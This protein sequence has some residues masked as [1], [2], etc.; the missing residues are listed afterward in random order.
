MTFERGTMVY[1]ADGLYD[2]QRSPHNAYLQSKGYDGDNPWADYANAGVV[3][4]E[5]A[6][7][8]MFRNAYEP[9]NIRE[10]DSETPWLTREAIRFVDQAKGPWCAH[11]S[12]IR[13]HWP[14][15]VP[16]PYHAV[17]EPEHGPPAERDLVERDDPHPVY[18]A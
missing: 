13:P 6:S 18:G 11:L 5:I 17:S 14:Y 2:Q 4:E 9:A 15:I 7:G 12:Y 3:G 1:G 16:A 10:E 8:W